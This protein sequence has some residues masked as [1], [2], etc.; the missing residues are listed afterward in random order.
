MELI[1]KVQG[2][3]IESNLKQYDV[4]LQ[5]WIDSINKDLVTDQDFEQARKD[6]A[7]TSGRP[8]FAFLMAYPP[9]EPL[10]CPR[11]PASCR[12]CAQVCLPPRDSIEAG[13]LRQM[14]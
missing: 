2:S 13:C 1:L 10:I 6:A 7:L 9:V 8:L 12:P 3:V 5:R 4:E 11:R 14:T